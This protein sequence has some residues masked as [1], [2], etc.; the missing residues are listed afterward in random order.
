MI[1]S[2]CI[3]WTVLLMIPIIQAVR[4]T[5]ACNNMKKMGHELK[6]RPFGYQETQTSQL[7]S[8]LLYSTNLD[9]KAKI[10][11][12][13]IKCSYTVIMLLLILILIPILGQINLIDI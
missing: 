10:F 13:P 8:F 1:T 4:L 3:L 7:D 2:D 6:S 12:I 9:M 11:F 5:D